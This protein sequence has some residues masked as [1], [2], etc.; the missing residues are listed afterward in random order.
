MMSRLRIGS[1]GP[2]KN[3]NKVAA[4]KAIRY[5]TGV[6]L[7]DAKDWIESA[8]DGDVIDLKYYPENRKQTDESRVQYEILQGE[9]YEIINNNTK[10]DIILE[11]TK[12]SAKMAIDEGENELATLLLDV[13]NRH[14]ENCQLKLDQEIREAEEEIDR[15]HRK[16]MRDIE[17]ETQQ[18]HAW[19]DHA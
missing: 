5:I 11:A 8:R 2:S 14:E 12:Q 4:I 6:G 1:R 15:K 7:K 17:L 9:G 13:I 16:K 10:I 3:P 19:P 18:N